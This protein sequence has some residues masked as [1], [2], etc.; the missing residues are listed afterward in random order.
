ML[1]YLWPFGIERHCFCTKLSP[2][3]CWER[4]EAQTL[5]EG[6]PLDDLEED[7]VYAFLHPLGFTLRKAIRSRGLQIVAEGR[8][9]PTA[10][11]TCVKVRL[12]LPE[13]VLI[14]IGLIFVALLLSLPMFGPS[15]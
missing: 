11:G 1:H 8:F 10:E 6:R 9:V 15:F 4:L 12:S 14:V 3:Q 7:G 5:S 13:G 2:E